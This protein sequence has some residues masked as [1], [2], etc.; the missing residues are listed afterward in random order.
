MSSQTGN[1]KLEAKRE[2]YFHKK[3]SEPMS[4][5]LLVKNCLP[6]T[7]IHLKVYNYG[8]NL[9]VANGGKNTI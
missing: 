6:K 3:D 1:D 5:I 7:T 4:H 8:T 9:R 2:G